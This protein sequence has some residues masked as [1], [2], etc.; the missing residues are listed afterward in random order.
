MQIKI[1]GFVMSKKG[2]LYADCRDNYAW[3]ADYHK[4]AISD[5]VSK[6]FFPGIWSEL[7][8]KQYVNEPD[9]Q[10][11]EAVVT[12]CQQ[13][14]FNQVTDIVN[15]SDTKYYTRNAYNNK[16][17]G[18]AT[19]VGL[20]LQEK[21]KTWHSVALGDTF[22]FFVPEGFSDFEKELRIHS[23]K[24]DPIT[25]DNFPDYFSSIG[26]Q[27]KGEKTERQGAL[28]AGTFYLMT[29]ALAEWFLKQGVN[30]VGKI[31]VWLDQAHFERY[32]NELRDTDEINN[33]DTTILIIELTD[34]G[35]TSFS[36]EESIVSDLKEL[37]AKQEKEKAEDVPETE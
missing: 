30:A 12:T 9:T 19:F 8:V 22:L 33:D 6:S 4:F 31:A 7:L 26:N 1:R 34:D 20:T 27:H 24:E 10:A 35:E 18:L 36:Y 25:F 23:S 5:G 37:I 15:G 32:I 21:E 2:E 11:L 13:C 29:D 28:T 17:P 16:T 14:W 3:N